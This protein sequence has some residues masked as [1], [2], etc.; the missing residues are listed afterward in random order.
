M[1]SKALFTDFVS[2]VVLICLLGCSLALDVTPNSS[3]DE[4]T[5]IPVVE[6]L[7]NDQLEVVTPVLEE[8]GELSLN[9]RSLLLNTS[10][11]TVIENML[12]EEGGS[13]YLSF[14]YAVASNQSSDS[15][16][17]EAAKIVPQEE[18]SLLAEEMVNTERSLLNSRV[19][20]SRAIP[21]SQRADFL[22]DLQK[23]V[24]KTLV[25]MVAGIIY[26]CIPN[27]IFWGKI[28]AAAA[29]SV[30]A[31]IVATTVMSLYRYYK[32]SDKPLSQTFQEWIIDV[33]TD[34]TA[35]YAVAASMT[36]VGKTMTNGP[37]VTGLIII[38]FSLYQV[39]DLVKPLLKKYNFDA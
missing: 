14:S 26:A 24:T 28:T 27:V 22:R 32:Y 38:V 23:L 36:A 2:I 29:V 9:S 10:G 8:Y 33:T 34:P 7:L 19:L 21:P 4:S 12:K 18:F 37:V 6:R 20:E 17:R 30:A 1:N 13:D 35:A 5:M 11:K 16:L 3:V 25:L 15:L 39:M 31:G